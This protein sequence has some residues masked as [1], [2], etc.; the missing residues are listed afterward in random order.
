V[1]GSDPEL[2]RVRNLIS[3]ATRRTPPDGTV[4]LTA[5]TRDGHAWLRV[6]DGCGGIPEPGRERVF[7]VAFQAAWR[8]PH[9]TSR[10]PARG[11]LRPSPDG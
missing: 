4:V 9:R 5:G 2:A 7:E 3:N 6:Q 1:L 8:A 11:W 10:T